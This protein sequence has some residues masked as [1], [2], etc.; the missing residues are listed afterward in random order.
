[1]RHVSEILCR[2]RWRVGDQAPWS[3][4]ASWC[5]T[6]AIF[7]CVRTDLTFHD[8]VNSRSNCHSTSSKVQSAS[9]F[10]WL[11]CA[12][13]IRFSWFSRCQTWNALVCLLA[14]DG[15]F[16]CC[17]VSKKSNDSIVALP[18]MVACRSWVFDLSAVLGVFLVLVGADSNASR[19]RTCNASVK[20][21]RP[22][23][24]DA[25]VAWK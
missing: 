25:I 18:L 21:A 11:P 3:R 12:F 24:R 10:F 14:F 5:L 7:C 23:D 19:T 20:A 2:C 9:R 13:Q 6:R 17:F 16:Y 1:M 4:M 8:Q 15:C 22:L